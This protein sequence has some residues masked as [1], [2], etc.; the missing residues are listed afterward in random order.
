MTPYCSADTREIQ[1]PADADQHDLVD[2]GDD[3]DNDISDSQNDNTDNT[4]GQNSQ[5]DQT[6]NAQGAQSQPQ[7]TQNGQGDLIQSQG[8]KISKIQKLLQCK[9]YKGAEWYRTKFIH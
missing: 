4:S 6:D 1:P 3:I 7:D 5:S 9:N 2:D 8:D